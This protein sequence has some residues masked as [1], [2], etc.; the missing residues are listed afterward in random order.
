MKK[1]IAL[2]LALLIGSLNGAFA[3]SEVYYLKNTTAAAIQPSV[4]NGF[5]SQ[6]FKLIDQKNP[7]YAVSTKDN[8]DYAV[9]ILQQSGGN[10][11]YYYQ[12]N[13]NKK[14]NKYVLK[15]AKKAGIEYEQ[16]F[17]SNI[18][19]TFDDIAKRTIAA[20]GSN[21]QNTYVFNNN[22]PEY[23]SSYA[24]TTT[25][26]NIKK[27][28]NTNTYS[29]YVANVESG[30]KI[31]IYLQ[32]AINTSSAVE[33]DRVIAVLTEDL[34]Y[35]GYVVAPQGSLVYGILTKARHATYGSRNG[36]VVID[37]NQLVT[38]EGKTFNIETEKIDFTVTNEGKVARVAS[39]VAVGAV[40]GVLGGLLVGA[41]SGHVGPAA[42]IGA[43]VGAGTALIGGA[44]ERGVDAEI[45][46]FT[47]M[48]ITLTKPFSTTV[49]Y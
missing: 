8:Q 48:E 20:S 16:S 42:A 39:S 5:Y 33:G 6:N 26:S 10:L 34:T 49:S 37:F 31:N 35:N 7:Y 30:T 40:V 41:L 17:N 43:G 21:A 4:L 32:S 18:I 24:A 22:E 46:S 3:F 38:P 29:G 13:D 47:E 15:A 36:R 19:A 1:F 23:S 9:V 44:A 45:P 14:I 2:F 28:K 25:T 12:S 27:Q 11:F